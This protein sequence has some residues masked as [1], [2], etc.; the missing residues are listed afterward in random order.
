MHRVKEALKG[1]IALLKLE[2]SSDLLLVVGRPVRI[3]LA[4][5][6]D[7]PLASLAIR[8]LLYER[9]RVLCEPHLEGLDLSH[10]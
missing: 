1:T 10:L 8:A 4:L 6:R 3:P 2:R 5:A 9:L 7:A